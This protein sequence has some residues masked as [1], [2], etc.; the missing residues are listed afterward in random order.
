MIEERRLTRTWR[1]LA[2]WRAEVAG[3]LE[4]LSVVELQGRGPGPFGAMVLA[5]LGAQVIRVARPQDV[6]ISD[7]GEIERMV[8]GHRRVDLLAR[9]RP[10]IAV[11]LK[12]D[13]GLEVVLRL[14]DAADVLVEGYRPG[15]A[16]RLGLG[17]EVCL[18]RNPRLIYARITGFGQ[19]GPLA[20]RPGHDVNYVALS[21]ALESL[22]RPGGV[23]TPPLNYLGDFGGG[24]MLLVVG[25][26]SALFERSTSG[27]GQVV[28]ASMV[29]GAA[30]LTTLFHGMRA[31]GLFSDEPGTHVL[32]LA[33][34]FYNVY[35]TADGGWISVGAGE[36]QFYEV[37]LERLG[38]DPELLERQ[39]D[40]TFWEADRERLAAVILTRTRSEWSALLE[41]VDA[42]ATPVL[43]LGE[44]ADHPH[45]VA[46]SSFVEVDGVVQPAPAPRFSRTPAGIP[47]PPAMAG[48][49]SVEILEGHGFSAA[50]IDALVDAG[51]VRQAERAS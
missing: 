51:V 27:R 32:S 34:P 48:D 16:E 45:H 37:L 12:D 29:E 7:E 43:A 18:G 47:G 17:P 33:A 44:V 40:P 36:P 24:G 38:L 41:E 10:S 30:L 49:Q 39:H 22:R 46:R 8:R 35:E 14:V 6:A 11:D 20:Q 19:D 5:D 21:G 28:D 25:V 31:E 23:P 42:C 1:E 13:R 3:P 9:G 4:G 2:D 26:L 15:V 50:E